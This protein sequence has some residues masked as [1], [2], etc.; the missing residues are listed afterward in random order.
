M[1]PRV[2]QVG[3]KPMTWQEDGKSSFDVTDQPV[4]RPLE[5][6]S[7]LLSH[8]DAK[9]LLQKRFE[10]DGYLFIRGLLDRETVL[11][12]RS[13]LLEDMA[14]QGGILDPGRDMTEGVLLER[15]GL[16]CVPFLE[17]RNKTTH[18]PLV[19]DVLESPS[20]SNFF[21][22]YIFGG[23]NTLTFDY[24]W[25]RVMPNDKFTGAHVD[26]VYMSRGSPSLVTTWI[27]FGDTEMEMGT[28][29][30]LQ[31]SHKLNGPFGK[32]HQT[33]GNF[34][35]EANPGFKG[36]GWF[37]EDPAEVTT[38]FGGQWRS[39]DFKAGDIIMF[40]MR[41]VHM[42]SVNTTNKARISCDVR[43]QPASDPVDSRYMG[44]NLG[45]RVAAGAYASDTISNSNTISMEQLKENWKI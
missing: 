18:H 6:S 17:G 12:A 40:G 4:L 22:N 32:F 36:T 19:R 9:A 8:P 24:K 43:W 31:G 21:S 30:V 14:S 23:R 2:V 44:N 41:T 38:K 28:L 42:S 10:D 25:L 37:T 26:N 15:C 29:C 27:P 34:D 5:D 35:T 3:P 39:E 20:L 16:G 13:F 45:E 33:Y 7:D 1:G 11:K